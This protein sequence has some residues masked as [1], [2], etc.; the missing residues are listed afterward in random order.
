MTAIIAD[1]EAR[2]AAHLAER[3]AVLWP[4]LVIAGVAANGPDARALLER[5]APDIAFLDIR[6]PG[7]TGLDVARGA[8]AGTHV[9][10]VT[11]YDQYAVTAFERAAF[12]YLLKPV[13]DERLAQTIAR[14]R[15]RIESAAQP[16]TG[17]LPELL[18]ALA[19]E[20]PGLA[21]PSGPARLAWIRAA[22]GQQVRLIAVEDVAYF[23][24]NDK[25]T[26]VFTADGEALIRTPLKDI[27]VQ[28]DP[29]RFWQVHRSTL[30][31]VAHVATTTRDMAGRVTLTLRGRPE[32]ITV[33][34]AYAHLFK[35]M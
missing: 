35:Q 21:V 1:D 3:L 27:A 9:V 24:S 5:E 12:D 25:Y 20:L 32:R 28:L 30:V 22:V 29:G 7:L 23:Q 31:N 17:R 10:F 34:R 11:A 14:L 2:L 15:E 18:A 19:R 13:S 16:E 8:G 33:S 26:S 4:E 6:M